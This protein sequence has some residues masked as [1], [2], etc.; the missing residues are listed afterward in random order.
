MVDLEAAEKLAFGPDVER[1]QQL[2]LCPAC[3]AYPE[4]DRGET[5][6]YCLRGDS[7]HKEGI[8]PKDCLCETC[9]IYKHGRLEGRNFFCL[10]GAALRKG[11]RNVLSGR[12]VTGL[13]EEKQDATARP[14]FV[15][16]GRDVHEGG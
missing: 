14:L 3:P 12:V 15:G 10:E 6:A 16:A 7:A 8:D 4:E 5:K 2:C 11:L 1:V 9:E 13:V